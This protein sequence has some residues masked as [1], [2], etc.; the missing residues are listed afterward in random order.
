MLKEELAEKF[1]NRINLETAREWAKKWRNDE[2]GYISHNDVRGFL[3]PI[4][5][6]Q[7]IV[8]SG[9]EAARAYIG[10]DSDGQARLMIVGTTYNHKMQTH[11][12]ML[13]HTPKPGYI[14]DFTLPCPRACGYNSPLNDI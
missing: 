8:E 1:D 10:V 4:E 9:A 3:M 12:D 13:P 6:L 7:Q 14:Y 11:D 5:G 2:L